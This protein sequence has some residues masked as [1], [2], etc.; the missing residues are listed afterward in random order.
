MKFV[1]A[2]GNLDEKAI[3]DS[4]YEMVLMEN[5]DELGIVLN[6]TSSSDWLLRYRVDAMLDHT[7]AYRVLRRRAERRGDRNYIKEY[8]KTDF[9]SYLNS[10]TSVGRIICEDVPAAYV[11]TNHPDAICVNTEFGNVIIVSEIIRYA[12]YF[13]TLSNCQSFGM[14]EIPEDITFAGFV[15]A[16]RTIMLT[17]SLDFDMDPR[18][19]IPRKLDY[20]INKLVK[21]QMQFVIGHEYT[22]Y[23]LGHKPS[24]IK[25]MPLNDSPNPYDSSKYLDIYQRN[26]DNEFEAD[27]HSITEILNPQLRR[28]IIQG[29]IL[30]FLN[31]ISY[32]SV[33]SRI[34]ED[35]ASL[36]THPPTEERL[37]RIAR[38]FGPSAGISDDWLEAALERQFSVA[39]SLSEYFCEDS[40]KMNIYG[41][42]YLGSWRGNP[43]LIG[44]ITE[45]ILI[46]SLPHQRHSPK[47]NPSRHSQIQPHPTHTTPL[48]Q[49]LR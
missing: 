43:L 5:S 1:D 40:S 25:R 29:S 26:W 47:T 18:G 33:Q 12:L 27:R 4:F 6:P 10:M 32:E 28:C 30:F 15:I 39:K 20:H 21:W 38:D 7:R 16:L 44:L 41:S 8:N 2:F 31:L 11:L 24:S 46:S 35:Y 37:R 17:E 34:D 48:A 36:S 9:T 22:H 3:S 14:S 42:V 45:Q 19:K 13:S 49:P 23:A